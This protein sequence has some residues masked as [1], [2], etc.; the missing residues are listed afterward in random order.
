VIQ[1]DVKTRHIPERA[2]KNF[3]ELNEEGKGSGNQRLQSA[4]R[5]L[6][7]SEGIR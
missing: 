4:Q 1:P 3:A 5:I 7:I 2:E 6:A